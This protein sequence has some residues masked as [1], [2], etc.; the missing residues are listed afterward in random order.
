MSTLGKVVTGL[1]LAPIA[2]LVLGIGGCE[3]K[4]AYYD[5]QVQRMCEKDG[6]AIVYEQMS[7]SPGMFKRMRGNL[8]GAPVV[9]PESARDTEVPVFLRAE[10]Q[11]IREGHPSIT[12]TEYAII[13]RSDAKILG[14]VVYYGR[15]GGDFPFTVSEAT[16]FQC[17]RNAELERKIF[18][19]EGETK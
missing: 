1:V 4:K 14:K 19:V 8:G 5:W 15:G 10:A 12:R 3:A 17:P 13:R 16:Y 11:R 6:G 7:I 2:I 18:S 9:P